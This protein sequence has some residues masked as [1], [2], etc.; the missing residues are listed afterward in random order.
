MHYPELALIWRINV[1]KTR[2]AIAIT[3]LTKLPRINLVEADGTG[4]DERIKNLPQPDPDILWSAQ[5]PRL[6]TDI[7]RL[8]KSIKLNYLRKKNKRGVSWV[9]RQV[10]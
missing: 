6:Q 4:F 3:Y 10:R 1:L 7:Y 9:D 5:Q 8:V 2:S